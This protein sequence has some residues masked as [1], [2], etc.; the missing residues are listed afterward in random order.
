MYRF[1]VDRLHELVGMVAYGC[2]LTLPSIFTPPSLGLMVC[3]T[4]CAIAI[5]WD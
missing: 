2:G 1:Y 3:M 5:G 4:A